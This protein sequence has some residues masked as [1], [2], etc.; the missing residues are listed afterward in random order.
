MRGGVA[1]TV[2]VHDSFS[3]D[4]SE[5]P[6]QPRMC[7]SRIREKRDLIS[8]E[9]STGKRREECSG[10]ILLDS[11]FDARK[12]DGVYC[13]VYIVVAPD[14]SWRQRRSGTGG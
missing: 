2:L 5:G 14:G 1:R 12:P 8:L 9:F 10:Q 3:F 4:L 11:T 13:V 7:E 6:T